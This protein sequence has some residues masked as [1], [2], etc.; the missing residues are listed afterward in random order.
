[1]HGEV[2]GEENEAEEALEVNTEPT[3]GGVGGR[4]N[5]VCLQCSMTGR[6]APH[7]GRPISRLSCQ[8]LPSVR[9]V[10]DDLTT[11]TSIEMRLWKKSA[12][13]FWACHGGSMSAGITIWALES[14]AAAELGLK[15]QERLAVPDRC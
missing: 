7:V 2:L 13:A 9:R 12:S 5:R 3:L 14:S 6:F 4:E 8:K 10:G 11:G 15:K 1:M